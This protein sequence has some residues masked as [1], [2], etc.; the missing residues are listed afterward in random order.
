M[1]FR[2]GSYVHDTDLWNV[3]FSI[4]PIRNSENDRML[5]RYQ[6]RLRGTLK[7]DSP[8]LLTSKIRALRNSYAV[9]NGD[10]GLYFDNGD[11]TA[12]VITNANS[13]DGVHV[14]LIDE[15]S[16]NGAEY[17]TFRSFSI[18]IYADYLPYGGI[19]IESYTETVQIVGTGGPR[20]V[21]IELIT[22]PPQLQTP[23]SQT[24]VRAIQQGQMITISGTPSAPPPYWPQYVLQDTFTN[25]K[26]SQS[27][28]RRKQL[29][30]KYDFL[31]PI[32]LSI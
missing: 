29:S 12:D 22:G 7:A 19:V 9:D 25:S 11:P 17:T 14:S 24:L 20:T 6:F 30:W 15:G 26:L 31:S 1:Y 4:R 5:N 18:D 10:A 16:D 21:G 28:G 2:Y 32:P 8:S 27:L 13:Y 23:V 3:H